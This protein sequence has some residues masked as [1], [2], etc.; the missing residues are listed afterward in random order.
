MISYELALSAIVFGPDGYRI[1]DLEDD[2]DDDHDKAMWAENEAARSSPFQAFQAQVDPRLLVRVACAQASPPHDQIHPSQVTNINLVAV[3][4]DRIEV[5]L[6]IPQ[7][8]DTTVQILVPIPFQSCESVDDMVEQIQTIMDP[9][10]ILKIREMEERQQASLEKQ[11]G[12]AQ[13]ATSVDHLSEAPSINDLPEWWTWVEL[14]RSF[15][16]ACTSLKSLLNEDDFVSDIRTLAR[17]Y[18]LP[19]DPT[20]KTNDIVDA[21]V[22]AVGPSGLYLRALVNKAPNK[23]I[24]PVAIRFDSTASSAEILRSSVLK[25]LDGV[26]AQIDE[27][28]VAT[29]P[30]VPPLIPLVEAP[31]DLSTNK[32][33]ELRRQPKSFDEEQRL[34]TK[35]AG[36]SDLGE[37]AF[38]I[39]KDLHMI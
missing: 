15:M 38:A 33:K 14:K 3:S 37:R 12:V 26:E 9:Q 10:A 29:V 20:T 25:L 18:Y 34:A 23:A 35:Y 1:E 4:L 31:G 5:G 16:D 27:P 24:V 28:L 32:W 6:G 36:I 30:L 21:R 7:T 13:E 39:L 8:Q 2:D 11:R 19:D 17:K 22:A